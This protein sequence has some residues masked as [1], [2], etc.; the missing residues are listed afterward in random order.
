MSQ[1]PSIKAPR[2]D[3]SN[4]MVYARRFQDTVKFDPLIFSSTTL[5]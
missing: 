4:P 3:S 1:T 5:S 2:M